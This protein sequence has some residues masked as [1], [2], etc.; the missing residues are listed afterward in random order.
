M[1]GMANIIGIPGS[2]SGWGVTF[3]GSPNPEPM[4]Y[5]D[6]G[7][8][9]EAVAFRATLHR[10]EKITAEKI[11]KWL[12]RDAAYVGCREVSAIRAGTYRLPVGADVDEDL[13]WPT[14][15]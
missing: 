11:A 6:C 13:A 1:D 15:I 12:E 8:E 4:D 9:E 10:M 2:K 3:D 7:T 5:R 14:S